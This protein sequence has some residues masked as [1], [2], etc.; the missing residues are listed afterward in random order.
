MSLFKPADEYPTDW[1]LPGPRLP[2][3]WRRFWQKVDKRGVNDCWNW[4]G[5]PK[6]PNDYGRLHIGN[7]GRGPKHKSAHR[8]IMEAELGSAI[9]DGLV[10]R[11][12]CDNP[13]C[14]NPLHLQLGTTKCN[15][16]DKSKR[17]RVSGER[18]PRAVLTEA[19]VRYIR[20]STRPRRALANQFG[21][22]LSTIDAV[23]WGRTWRHV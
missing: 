6:R 1:T 14:V 15:G 2:I 4:T 20:T 16:Q 5:G 11:H 10:V 18:G 21:V 23:I 19:S 7:G 22:A 9:P 13:K 17:L 8:L 12:A 3:W